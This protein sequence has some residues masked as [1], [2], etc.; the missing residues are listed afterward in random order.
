MAGKKITAKQRAAIAV[1]VEGKTR[2]QAAAIAGVNERTIYKWQNDAPFIAALRMAETQALTSAQGALIARIEENITILD[3]IKRDR[4]ASDNARIRAVQ[5]QHENMLA[6]R[7]ALI[8]D[9]RIS[10]IEK[11]L[12]GLG[13]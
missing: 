7:A 2:A 11:R 5:L 6:W 12:E 4:A 8:T 10:D 13:K 9:E 1:L 3:E